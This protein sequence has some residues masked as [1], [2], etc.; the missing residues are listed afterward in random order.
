M[1][2]EK[3]GIDFFGG[4]VAIVRTALLK[5]NLLLVLVKSEEVVRQTGDHYF[6]QD[7]DIY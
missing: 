5:C 6:M 1:A 2:T 3:L 7:V 4:M